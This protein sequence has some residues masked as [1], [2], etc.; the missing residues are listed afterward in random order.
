M[1]PD[2]STVIADEN[3]DIPDDL[4][5]ASLTLF[6]Q[7]PPLL[8]ESKLHDATAIDFVGKFTTCLVQRSRVTLCQFAR[9]M[10]PGIR[11]E[12]TT[13]NL[14]QNVIFQP[15]AVQP[16]KFFKAFSVNGVRTLKKVR[17]R[18]LQQRQ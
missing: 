3:R 4:D 6:M 10:V 8:P 9:P 15:P 12:M 5:P 16:A 7:R 2:V 14:K 18:F 13:Q 17:R 11:I 1:C